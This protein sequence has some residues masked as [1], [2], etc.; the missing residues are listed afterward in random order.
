MGR[1]IYPI[2]EMEKMTGIH[3]H[4]HLIH[5]HYQLLSIVFL[6]FHGFSR[7]VIFD[8]PPESW[9]PWNRHQ[10]RQLPDV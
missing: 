4:Y 5:Y 1:I 7:E 9:D 8:V 2:Y 3:H 6:A 10:H